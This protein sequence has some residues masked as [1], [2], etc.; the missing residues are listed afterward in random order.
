[1]NEYD[2]EP[3]LGP[4]EPDLGPDERDRDLLD[5][6]WEEKYY[7]GRVRT[8]NWR[9]IYTGLALLALIGLVVPAV[10]MVAR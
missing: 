7:S 4:D 9:A 10:L 2:D 3:G 1:M 5:G 6:S 8:R